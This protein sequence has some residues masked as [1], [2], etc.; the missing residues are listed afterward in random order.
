MNTN[1][2]PQKPDNAEWCADS[3]YWRI[4][5]KNEKGQNIGEWLYWLAPT[6]HFYGQMFFENGIVT[7]EITY[8]IDGT[9]YEKATYKNGL[10]HGIWYWQASE[11]ETTS[12]CVLHDVPASTF[13]REI[14]YKNDKFILEKFF[15][16]DGVEIFLDK[17]IIVKKNAL[18]NAKKFASVKKEYDKLIAERINDNKLITAL[19]DYKKWITTQDWFEENNKDNYLTI[20]H[21]PNAKELEIL[22]DKFGKLPQ[23]YLKPL[24]D[25]G[26]SEFTYDC[27]KTKMLS[28]KQIIEFYDVVQNEMDFNDDF[29]EEIEEKDGI[30][31]SKYI[32]VMAGEGQDG[33]WA[34]LNLDKKNNG[35]IL[36]WDADQPGDLGSTFKNL[37]EFILSSFSRA[38]VHDPLRLT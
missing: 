31:F 19:E 9:Y 15:T 17:K 12:D 34:L 30:D 13:F 27:Y 1:N 3:N 7:S 18:T 33:C 8:H 21:A 20:Q 14:E 16:K 37:E 23:S 10:R 24:V 22:V 4:G 25:F 28:P 36:Y 35:Q 2:L 6:D 38:K 5:Q 26:L 29:R 11:N 32:P